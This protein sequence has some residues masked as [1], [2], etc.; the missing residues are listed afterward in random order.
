MA[1]YN[2]Y[3]SF[4]TK[5]SIDKKKRAKE[6]T[7]GKKNNKLDDFVIKSSDKYGIVIEVRYNDVYVL[8][9]EEVVLAKLRNDI[10]MVC[11]QVLFPGDKVVLNKSNN[12]YFIT[13]M[14][15]RTSVLS[16][17][18]K[19][20]TRLDDVGLIK[21]IAANVDIA[22]IVVAAK[23]PPLHPKFIDRYLMILQN[24]NIKA[25][26]CLNKCDLKTNKEEEILNTYRELNIPVLCTST[27]QNIGIDDL[28]KYLFGKQAILVG[29]SGVGKSSLTNA[30]M[31]DDEIKTGHI[32][33]K[34]KRGRHT[35][36]SSKYYIWEA[37]SSIIDTPGI[38]SLDVSTFSPMEIQDYFPEF[39]NFKE[40]CKYHDCLHYNEPYD[41]C[42]IKQAVASGLIN[43]NRYESYLRIMNDV[44]NCNNYEDILDEV[45]KLKK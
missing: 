36:T 13:N 29:N 26:I 45:N 43:I 8:Y 35:T 15:E 4:K 30:I 18:K 2:S 37:N 25:L 11:N 14:L 16:R 38:R 44:L 12:N 24:S 34:S 6:K 7:L 19:D 21:N 1:H 20:S 5:K 41:S 23:E 28:K 33:D 17:V 31:N 27:Y 3:E 22:V 42:I 9:D 39:N 40:K 10:N 32:S